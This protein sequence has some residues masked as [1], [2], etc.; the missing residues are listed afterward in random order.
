MSPPA[1]NADR[2]PA[3]RFDAHGHAQVDR[4]AVLRL[5]LPL[6][7]NSVIQAVLS[8]TDTWFVGHIST[9]AL[10]A[11]ASVYFL[12]MLVIFFLSGVTL[13]VQTLVAQAFGARRY[14][15]ASEAL[16]S[17]LWAALLVDRG[18]G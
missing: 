6:M 8:L 17:G 10:A 2:L 14:R 3:R 7:L 13:C 15:R 11:I 5:A 12:L 1:V 16:W 4:G 9:E 18:A